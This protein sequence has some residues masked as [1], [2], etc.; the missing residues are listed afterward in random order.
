MGS[1]VIKYMSWDLYD[2]PKSAQL[3]V[4]K[5][6]AVLMVQL[7]QSAKS[8]GRLKVSLSS[9]MTYKNKSSV[10]SVEMKSGNNVA[11]LL[12]QILFIRTKFDKWC[13]LFKNE[14]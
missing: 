13:T 6:R 8:T 7:K 4:L 1:I 11:L 3:F 5:T 12:Y 9:H 14:V 10:P 2:P